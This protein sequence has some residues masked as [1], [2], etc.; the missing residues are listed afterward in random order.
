VGL[1]VGTHF[2]ITTSQLGNFQLFDA[3]LLRAGLGVVLLASRLSRLP[4]GLISLFAGGS[5]VCVAEGGGRRSG[6]LGG[7][8]QIKGNIR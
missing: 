3:L 7:T 5:S 1:F 6:S 8:G 2:A 4:G